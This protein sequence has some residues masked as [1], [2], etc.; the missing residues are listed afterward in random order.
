MAP[1]CTQQLHHPTSP[2][3]IAASRALA[4][5]AAFAGVV[6]VH[7]ACRDLHHLTNLHPSHAPGYAVTSPLNQDDDENTVRLHH[8]QMKGTHNSYHVEPFL[9]AIPQWQYT[10]AALGEQLEQ[11]NVRQFEF[12]VYYNNRTGQFDVLHRRRLDAETTCKHLHQCLSQLRRWS[13]QHPD[14]APLFIM[15]EPKDQFSAVTAESY[16]QQLERAV[17]TAW[18]EERIITPDAVR[19]NSPSLAVAISQHGWPTVATSQGKAVFTLLD[20]H[21]YRNAYTYNGQ[22]LDTRL[23]FVAA[24]P[25]DTFAAVVLL[26]DPIAQFA[27][28]QQSVQDG[29]LVRTRADEDTLEARKADP[30]RLRAALA[31]GAHM[32]STDFPAPVSDIHYWVDLPGGTSMRCNPVTAPIACKPAM[33]S[34]QPSAANEAGVEP[35]P[36]LPATSTMGSMTQLPNYVDLAARRLMR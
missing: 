10:H 27:Q 14:H 33:F 2:R 24:Q 11:H 31:S 17:R 22:S 6:S 19:A 29:F 16:F 13:E 20:F 18:P 8:L 1:D 7:V 4:L 23:M 3:P 21:Q 34:Y 12:D 9:S 15:L 5:W 28:I 36:A 26:D 25:D 32:I 30:T 35:V